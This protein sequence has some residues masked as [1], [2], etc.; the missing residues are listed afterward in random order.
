MKLNEHMQEKIEETLGRKIS[1]EQ[2]GNT[3]DFDHFT[4]KDVEDFRLILDHS[5]SVYLVIF[6]RAKLKEKPSLR[7]AV[8][9][10]ENVVGGRE[11]FEEWWDYWKD[12]K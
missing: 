11:S 9:Y 6:I 8:S 4:D 10:S 7:K 5:S 3:L 1:D 12:E 2:I